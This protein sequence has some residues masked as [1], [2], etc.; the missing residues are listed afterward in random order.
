MDSKGQ[1]A[2][3]G[4]FDESV[5]AAL[6][7]WH[8]GLPSRQCVEQYLPRRLEP[9]RTARGVLGQLRRDLA[10]YARIRHREDLAAVFEC[11]AARRKSV[12]PRLQGALNELRALPLPAPLI[13]DA[14]DRWFPA[15]IAK[16]L[17]AHKIRTL[18]DLT[19]RTP[20]RRQWWV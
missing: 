19:V 3:G 2:A 8:Q 20:R 6:R 11:Q 1:Q 15:R 13:G 18:A 9:G 4:L 7:A 16:V 10:Q 14:V 12:A 5:A 17:Q